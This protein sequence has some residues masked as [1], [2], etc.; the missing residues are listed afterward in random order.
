[1]SER[2]ANSRPE[3]NLPVKPYIDGSKHTC[4][5]GIS[6]AER[7][8]LTHPKLLRDYFDKRSGTKDGLFCTDAASSTGRACCFFE[9]RPTGKSER[10]T[11]TLRVFLAHSARCR[12]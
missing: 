4:P 1:M 5:A 8:F 3:Q 12:A 9:R 6:Q 11:L 10:A 2:P 7:R